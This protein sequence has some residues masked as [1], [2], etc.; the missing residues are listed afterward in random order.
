MLRVLVESRCRNPSLSESP[1]YILDFLLSTP[2][3]LQLNHWRDWMRQILFLIPSMLYLHQGFWIWKPIFSIYSREISLNEGGSTNK[4]RCR[5]KKVTSNVS[6][7]DPYVELHC[8]LRIKPK[9]T[10]NFYLKHI[11]LFLLMLNSSKDVS[12]SQSSNK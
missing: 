11:S 1:Q 4:R 7:M 3:T 10:L 5:E 6:H 12:I 9:S 2:H 8:D